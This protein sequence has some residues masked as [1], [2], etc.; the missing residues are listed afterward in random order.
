MAHQH[1]AH[2]PTIPVVQGPTMPEIRTAYAERNRWKVGF[3][4]SWTA[5]ACR[6][7]SDADWTTAPDKH[8]AIY[9]GG[10]HLIQKI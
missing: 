6:G 3:I 9:I 8:V 4:S 7:R 10:E 2:G 5:A 1:L